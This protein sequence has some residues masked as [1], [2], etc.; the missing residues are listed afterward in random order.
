MSGPDPMLMGFIFALASAIVAGG[1]FICLALIVVFVQRTVKRVE[2][3]AP[4]DRGP[5]PDSALLLYALAVFFWPAAFLLGA[6]LMKQART[7][8]QGRICVFIGLANITL[9]VLG[10][11]LG[12]TILGF[13]A[14]GMVLN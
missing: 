6:Y 14:P 8:R 11:C 9:V 1:W 12:M 3:A 2:A 4:Q 5:A 7:V 13:V 10:T